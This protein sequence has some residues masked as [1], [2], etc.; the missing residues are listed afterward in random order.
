MLFNLCLVDQ[1]VDYA[2]KTLFKSTKS[3]MTPIIPT[4]KFVKKSPIVTT[5]ATEGS[6]QQVA[7]TKSIRRQSITANKKV[8]PSLNSKNNQPTNPHYQI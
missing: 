8:V 7:T 3:P 5:K 1:Q 4:M 6:T 2:T